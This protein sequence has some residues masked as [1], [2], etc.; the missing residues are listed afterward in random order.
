MAVSVYIPSPFRRLTANREYVSVEGHNVSEVLDAVNAQ[1]PGFDMLAD[2]RGGFQGLYYYYE[3]LAEALRTLGI[4]EIVTPGGAR[5][6]WRAEL[7]SVTAQVTGPD[8]S[9]WTVPMTWQSATDLWGGS[10]T[11]PANTRSFATATGL[12]MCNR[13]SRPGWCHT[14]TPSAVKQY[15]PSSPALK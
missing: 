13:G 9:Q 7:I 12:S 3:T 15:S 14:S 10:V 5:H 6:D 1:Y 11:L 8:Q 4:D 2:P